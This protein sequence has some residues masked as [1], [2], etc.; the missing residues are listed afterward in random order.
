MRNSGLFIK[1]E[2]KRKKEIFRIDMLILIGSLLMRDVF[3]V[4]I[5][6]NVFTVIL[7]FG[8]PFFT[9]EDMIAFGCSLP[10]FFGGIE[11]GNICVVWI[12]MYLLKFK[13]LR[14]TPAK[15]FP[16]LIMVYFIVFEFIIDAGNVESVS[17]IIS[18]GSYLILFLLIME[19]IDLL[20][21]DEIAYVLKTFLALFFCVMFIILLNTIQIAG[22]DF[23]FKQVRFGNP[24]GLIGQSSQ[25]KGD[26]A[27]MLG[28]NQNYIALFCTVS[29]S[30]S[31][32]LLVK[33]RKSLLYWASF[34]GSLFFGFLTASKA[35]LL[36]MFV[37]LLFF[38]YIQGRKRRDSVQWDNWFF[39]IGVAILVIFL[40]RNVIY[41][42]AIKNVWERLVLGIEIGDISTGRV[43]TAKEY[44]AF[45]Q[46]NLN[47]LVYGMG[48]TNIADKTRASFSPHNM[49]L[50]IIAGT[51]I[52]GAVLWFSLIVYYIM[53]A[54]SVK[55]NIGFCII[56]LAAY[57]IFV[58]S[59]QFLTISNIYLT[60]MPVLFLLR[61]EQSIQFPKNAV[62]VR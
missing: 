53:A 45:F 23:I 31:I 44:I 49:I 52:I 12:I 7:L 48:V 13:L 35:Y 57:L 43:D 40:F 32:V 38:I 62:I 56:G 25:Y 26:T 36:T 17:V 42:L 24:K 8:M 51:G 21:Q 18:I 46:K 9:R 6:A 33:E 61:Y 4:A 55:R 50:D 20:R 16:T 15:I 54:K 58:Q 1:L 27:V 59:I 2:K 30:I 10:L 60:M 11:T 22:S 47:Y 28:D 14:R 37:Q 3:G 5:Q 29:V 34:F 19:N 39:L 41:Q